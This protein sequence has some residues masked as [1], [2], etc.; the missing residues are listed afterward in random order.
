MAYNNFPIGYQPAQIYYPQQYSQAQYMQQQQPVQQPQ[1]QQTLTPP[2]IHA[3]IV[4]VENEQAA[5]SYPLSAG[6]SQMMIAR[7]DSAIYVKTMYPNGQYKLDAFLKRPES[8]RSASGGSDIYITRDE[9]E[10]RLQEIL[11]EREEPPKP[12][13]KTKLKDEEMS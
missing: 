12:K 9:F 5:E 10:K 3:E 1:A 2:T 7:D 8:P 6:S 11:A 13:P 4:Q